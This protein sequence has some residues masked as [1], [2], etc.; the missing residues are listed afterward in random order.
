M[1]GE[2]GN[3]GLHN[4]GRNGGKISVS[5]E[6]VVRT[7]PRTG[8][9]SGDSFAEYQNRIKRIESANVRTV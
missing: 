8:Q 2:S 5:K 4:G 6:A 9:L 1:N 7:I 3:T